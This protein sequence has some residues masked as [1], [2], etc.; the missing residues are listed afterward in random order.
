MEDAVRNPE[1]NTPRTCADDPGQQFCGFLNLVS[2][3]VGFKSG[4]AAGISAISL[5]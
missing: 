1:I 2:G 4:R 3:F 5:A